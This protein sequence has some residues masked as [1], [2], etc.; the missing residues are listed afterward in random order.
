MIV[1]VDTSAFLSVL[2]S[3]NENHQ[4]AKKKWEHLILNEAVLVCAN[5]VLVETFALVQHRI[6]I[7]AVRAFHEDVVPILRI[8]WI[9]EN[10]Y[11]VG[12]MGI[13]AAN[14]KQLSLVDCVSFSLMRKLGIK[15]VFAFDRHFKEQGFECIS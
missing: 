5:Y 13:L 10:A 14:R 4:K 3:D 15:T 1:F 9:D 8:E 11:Q 12:V 7:A 2:D 6:G